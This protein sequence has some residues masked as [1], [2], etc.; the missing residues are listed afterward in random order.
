MF[1]PL[2]KLTWSLAPNLFD[3]DD[4]STWLKE[5]VNRIP[6]FRTKLA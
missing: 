1:W 2:G 3:Y 4:D 6:E 5:F